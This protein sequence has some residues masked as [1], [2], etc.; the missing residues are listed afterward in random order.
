MQ[1][2]PTLPY[3]LAETTS[4]RH[5]R[6]LR[7]DPLSRAGVA[8]LLSRATEPSAQPRPHFEDAVHFLTGGSPLLLH[9]LVADHAADDDMSATHLA[10]GVLTQAL[11]ACLYRGDP[12]VLALARALAVAS[13]DDLVL[14]SG[15]LY[16]VGAAR[17]ALGTR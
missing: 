7:L 6:R 17:A 15:S 13:P 10:S 12:A 14:V 16:V 2:W 1:H 4:L 11:L 8:E 3:F 9:A 5:S